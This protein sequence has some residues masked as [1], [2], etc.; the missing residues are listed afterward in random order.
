MQTRPWTSLRLPSY[1]NSGSTRTTPNTRA[2][3]RKR[4]ATLSRRSDAPMD[5][6]AASGR[7]S[8]KADARETHR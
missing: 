6:L 1:A 5:W 8:L 7:D 4:D 3:L 2:S